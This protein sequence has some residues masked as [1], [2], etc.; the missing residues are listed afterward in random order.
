MSEGLSEPPEAKSLRFW[1]FV[2]IIAAFLTLALSLPVFWAGDQSSNLW[3]TCIKSLYSATRLLFLHFEPE[4]TQPVPLLLLLAMLCAVIFVSAASIAVVLEFFGKRLHLLWTTRR[5]GHA[6]VCGLGP[7]GRS[8]VHGVRAKA[9]PVI[10]LEESPG[11]SASHSRKESAGL[12]IERSI[13]SRQLRDAGALRARYLFAALES[14]SSN[15]GVAMRAVAL[16]GGRETRGHSSLQVFAHIVDPQ[17]RGFLRARRA[18]A[19][20]AGSSRVTTFNVFENGSRQLFSKYPLDRTPI[21]PH[22]NRAVQLILLGFGLMGE[23]VLVQACRISHYVNLKK[24]KVV[25]I[26]RQAARKERIFRFRYPQLDQVCAAEFFE[27]DAEEAI[28]HQRISQ[29]CS[30]PN[31]LSTVVVA[32]DND[33]RSLS[34]ALSLIHRQN[35]K[36]PIRVRLS[37]PAGLATLIANPSPHSLSNQLTAFGSLDEAGALINVLDQELDTLAR[38]LH[39]DYR[40][41]RLRGGASKDDPALQDWKD[42]D[43]DYMDSNR[44]A[45]DHIPVKLRAIACH[46]APARSEPNQV[47]D[48]FTVEEVELLARMEHL[49]WNAERF[50]AGWTYAPPPRNT[51]ERTSPYLVPWDQ[52]EPG[53]Q[54]YDREAVRLIPGLLRQI[55]QQIYR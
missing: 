2:S 28:A 54:E 14:D 44:Q 43:E 49:R 12:A 34:V 42:L 15:V 4:P 55:G 9:L 8:L 52:L 41:R 29:S 48:Q 31:T 13:G 30:D 27:L 7:L 22:D 40:Q 24:L 19:S 51:I 38:A 35:I 3:S 21:P 39:H 53:I 6:V 1:W 36:A 16:S 17:L 32:F 50:L 10:T 46:P 20:A 25:V 33:A 11:D 37:D 45:A 18:F 5:G 26:D 23:A 47:V